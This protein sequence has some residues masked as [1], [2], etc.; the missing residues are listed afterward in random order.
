[1]NRAISASRPLLETRFIVRS[2]QKTHVKNQIGI[3]WQTRAKGER[4]HLDEERLLL[5]QAEMALKQSL[6]VARTETRRV[7]R[8]LNAF[9]QRSQNLPLASDALD[10]RQPPRQGM[11][12]YNGGA[13]PRRR[14]RGIPA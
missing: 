10:Q 8:Q 5:G 3:A 2:G 7:D 13:P 6:Q 11:A 4:S 14:N 1:M 9:P 12:S